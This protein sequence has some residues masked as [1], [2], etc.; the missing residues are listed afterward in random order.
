[1]KRRVFIMYADF[2]ILSEIS[3]RLM[4]LPELFN[5]NIPK[6]LTVGPKFSV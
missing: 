4:H 1:M 3:S 5:E 2:K 6:S